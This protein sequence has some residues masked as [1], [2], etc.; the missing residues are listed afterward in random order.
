ME[1]PNRNLGNVYRIKV[2]GILNPAISEWLGDV[3]ISPLEHGET[4]LEGEFPDQ[5]ALRGFVDQLW[6]LNYTVLSIEKVEIKNEDESPN[7]KE[8]R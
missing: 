1:L 8:S 2:R 6:N 5:P 3:T 7:R 4:L